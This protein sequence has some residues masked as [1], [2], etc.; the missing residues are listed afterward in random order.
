MGVQKLLIK[1]MHTFDDMSIA[2]KCTMNL[3]F[4]KIF[5]PTLMHNKKWRENDLI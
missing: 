4:H 2:L 5:V 1:S 3:L